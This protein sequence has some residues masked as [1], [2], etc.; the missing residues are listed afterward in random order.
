[1]RINPRK[2]NAAVAAPILFTDIMAYEGRNC[3]GYS[4]TKFNNAL[5]L[6]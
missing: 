6:Q 4:S 2:H 3:I 5:L 1:M